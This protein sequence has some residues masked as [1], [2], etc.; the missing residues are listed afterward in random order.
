ML[1]G[2]KL[3]MQ[4]AH[5]TLGYL[6]GRKLFGVRSARVMAHPMQPALA[7]CATAGKSV[8]GRDKYFAVAV[9][10]FDPQAA[11]ALA[12]ELPALE[13]ADAA[14]S[15]VVLELAEAL[16]AISTCKPAAVMLL[17]RNTTLRGLSLDL[18]QESAVLQEARATILAVRSSLA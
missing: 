15:A 12:A 18:S 14:L 9:G 16:P 13:S 11:A 1:S 3:V 7:Q 4:I 8:D 10:G 17:N 6:N 2:I 5:P